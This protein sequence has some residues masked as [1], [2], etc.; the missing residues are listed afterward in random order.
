MQLRVVFS[1]CLAKR[2]TALGVIAITL[3]GCATTP[4]SPSTAK[5]VPRDR[6]IAFQERTPENSATLVVTRDE[7]FVGSACYLS[8]VVNGTHAARFDVAE[9]AEFHVAPGEQLL[10][11]GVDLMGQMLCGGPAGKDYWTQR[12]TVIRPG[13][14]K[15]FRLT[16]DANGGMD[17]Q[18]AEPLK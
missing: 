16:I 18:R 17:I 6:L 2:A 12:E 7:G 13:E 4:V 1:H 9:T 14:T 10:R 15:F 8:F 3:S 11:V 5:Q